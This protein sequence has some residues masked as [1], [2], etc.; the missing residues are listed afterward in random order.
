M[1]VED[2]GLPPED[3]PDEIW[4]GLVGPIPVHYDDDPRLEEQRAAHYRAT[5]KAQA[6]HTAEELLAGLTDHDW[7]VRHE[8][9]DRLIARWGQDERTLPALMRAALDDPAWQVRDA[10]VMRLH[11][12]DKELVMPVLREA[13][14]DEHE[15]VRSAANYSLAQLGVPDSA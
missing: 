2:G 4:I 8:V 10:V 14:R 3:Q 13:Q 15:D 5:A 7:R 6:M 9:V 11:D 1:V 12:F